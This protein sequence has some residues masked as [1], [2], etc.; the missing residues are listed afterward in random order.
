LSKTIAAEPALFKFSARVYSAPFF[1]STKNSIKEI[2][3]PHD[4]Y[5]DPRTLPE[6]ATLPPW[7]EQVALY[8]LTSDYTIM[9]TRAEIEAIQGPMTDKDWDSL[10]SIGGSNWG[11]PFFRIKAANGERPDVAANPDAPDVTANSEA[12]ELAE[13][14][15]E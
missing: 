9:K 7:L 4:A 8:F 13:D 2:S 3:M 11:H 6:G 14:F 10:G 15:N 12:L 1:S 5:F